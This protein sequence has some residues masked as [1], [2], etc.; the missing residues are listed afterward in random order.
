MLTE[1]EVFLT[2][3]IFDQTLPG[4]RADLGEPILGKKKE[5]TERINAQRA[6][7]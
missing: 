5:I 2:K 3:F 1:F 7:N 6:S 4:A